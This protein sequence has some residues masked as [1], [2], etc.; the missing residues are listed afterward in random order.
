MRTKSK[1]A[2]CECGHLEDFHFS[3]RDAVT[4]GK[5]PCTGKW[6]NCNHFIKK[7]EKYF[8]QGRCGQCG[9]EDKNCNCLNE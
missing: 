2:R 8:E 7:K 6:C 4:K 1:S 9:E 3:K 5:Q